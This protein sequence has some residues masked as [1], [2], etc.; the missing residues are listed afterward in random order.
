MLSLFYTSS[1]R[2]WYL[3]YHNYSLELCVDSVDKLYLMTFTF[4]S[5]IY[6]LHHGLLLLKLHL[7]R[8]LTINW[9]EDKFVNYI[10]N[11]TTLALNAPYITLKT[12]LS[13]MGL[14]LFIHWSFSSYL[15]GYFKLITNCFIMDKIQIYGLCL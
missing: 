15:F 10:L 12:T 8:I 7:N 6:S 4:L 9:K 11:C 13:K 3:H 5:T 14:D 2:I 1:I